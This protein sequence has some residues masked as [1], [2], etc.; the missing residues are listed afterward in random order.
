MYKEL[1]VGIS[2][3]A[4]TEK[5]TKLEKREEIK[6][7]KT[8]YLLNTCFKS[9]LYSKKNFFKTISESEAT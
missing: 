3:Y 1:K 7:D 6:R 8:A 5:K 4:A 9:K 2:M